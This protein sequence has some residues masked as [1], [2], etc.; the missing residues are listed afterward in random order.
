MREYAL[1]KVS[2]V[3]LDLYPGT[4]IKTFGSYRT[5]LYLPTR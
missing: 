3:I 1:K 2:D 5:N 4:I